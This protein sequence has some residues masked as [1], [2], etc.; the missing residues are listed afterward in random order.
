MAGNVQE[1]KCMD[2][3]VEV[4]NQRNLIIEMVGNVNDIWILKHIYKFIINMTRED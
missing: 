4:E 1:E 2:Y 3:Y